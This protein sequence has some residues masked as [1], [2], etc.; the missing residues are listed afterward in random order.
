MLLYF[1][2]SL[3]PAPD[4]CAL[5]GEGQRAFVRVLGVQQAVC[6]LGL[7]RERVGV[8]EAL[9]F[10]QDLLDLRQRERCIDGD[11]REQALAPRPMRPPDAV[12]SLTSPYWLAST[13]EIGSPVS[14]TLRATW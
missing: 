5:F 9:R 12:S 2:W 11:A 4:G 3:A 1:G 8:I 13:A 7:A 6:V 14:S 10:S